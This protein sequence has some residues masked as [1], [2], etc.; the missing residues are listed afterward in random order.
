MASDDLFLDQL[1]RDQGLETLSRDDFDALAFGTIKLDKNDRVVVYNRFEGELAQRDQTATIGEPFFET[2]APCTNNAVFRGELQRMIASG[3]KN[4]RFDYE[5]RFPWGARS[6]RI[7][8][9]VPNAN[10]RWIFVLP[11]TRE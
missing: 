11:K 7:Q 10:E 8:L 4:A 1:I 5:F 2:V 3:R 9:W 6:V